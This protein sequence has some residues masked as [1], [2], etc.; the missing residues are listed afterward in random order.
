MVVKMGKYRI[1]VMSW[2]ENKHFPEGPFQII[3]GLY[4]KDVCKKYITTIINFTCK[5]LALITWS[6]H[7]LLHMERV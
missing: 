5:T 6:I 3:V 1:E 2:Q 4:T 7:F